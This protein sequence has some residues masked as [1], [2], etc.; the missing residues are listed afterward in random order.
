MILSR[1]Q[2]RQV[3]RRAI[4]ECGMSGL[5][6]MENAGRGVA[7]AMLAVG[8]DGPVVVCCGKGNNGADGFVIARHLD[9]RSISVRVLLFADP[10]ELSGDAAANWSIVEKAGIAYDVVEKD[11]AIEQLIPRLIVAD[12]IV[13]ALLGTGATGEPQPPYN[14]AIQAINRV[15]KKVVAVDLPSGL[16]C[17]TGAAASDTI[18]ADR[19]CTFVAVK[20]G[21]LVAGAEHF[22]GRVHVIDIG[23]PRRLVQEIAGPQS[24]SSFSDA[25]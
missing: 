21:F 15:G 20:P 22:T 3:D 11:V 6:L 24:R 9:N 18:V 23:V 19:T 16:D 4:D 25:S 14:V 2:V 17:D 13:D 1:E 12:W 7:E 10:A 8:L 5:V